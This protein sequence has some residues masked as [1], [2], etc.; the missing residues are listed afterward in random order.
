MR[1]SDYIVRFLERIGVEHVFT[2]Y[3]GAIAPLG[4]AL[5]KAG[6]RYVC[7]HHEQA[8][9]MAA[10]GYARMREGVGA[11]FV[12]SGPGGTNAITGLVGCWTDHAPVMFFSG[13]SFVNQTIRN[14]GT[15]QI[16]VQE[17]DIINGVRPWTKHAVMLT[18]ARDVPHHLSLAHSMATKGRPGPVWLDLPADILSADV[19]S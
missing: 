8:C 17:I 1:V 13:Q 15:R 9:A 3:G 6:M 18:D 7:C 4:D 19:G 5:V 14:T 12:T 11:V 16:G 2:V 10:E